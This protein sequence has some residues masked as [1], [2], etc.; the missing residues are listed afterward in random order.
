MH[1]C[2]MLISTLQDTL[3]PVTLFSYVMLRTV[4]II[5]STRQTVLHVHMT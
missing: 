1:R 2:D 4:A 3:D 5:S